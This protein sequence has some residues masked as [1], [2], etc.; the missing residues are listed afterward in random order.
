MELLARTAYQLFSRYRYGLWGYWFV[1]AALI[2]VEARWH[3]LSRLTLWDITT[4]IRL[5]GT[6]SHE[7]APPI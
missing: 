7:H 4:L 5:V 3:I 2:V 6:L 1:N